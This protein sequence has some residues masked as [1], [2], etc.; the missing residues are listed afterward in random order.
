VTECHTEDAMLV[1]VT[2]VSIA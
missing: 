2:S 1:C